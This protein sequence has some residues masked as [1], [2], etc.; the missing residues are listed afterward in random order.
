MSSV[1]SRVAVPRLFS[2]PVTLLFPMPKKFRSKEKKREVSNK[3]A[4]NHRKELRRQE[5]IDQLSQLVEESQQLA[6]SVLDS[7]QGQRDS[8]RLPPPPQPSTSSSPS[9]PP[10]NQRRFKLI[11]EKGESS[12][13]V[14]I[15]DRS[16]DE[17]RPAES[18][19]SPRNRSSKVIRSSAEPRRRREES[20]RSHHQ[21]PERKR[22]RR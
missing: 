10:S 12:R 3:R 15:V 7:V 1:K 13:R 14:Q 5:Q 9:I 18:S 22:S 4:E 17:A 19:P 20:G 6:E 11:S 21:V 2:P 16:K 8:A